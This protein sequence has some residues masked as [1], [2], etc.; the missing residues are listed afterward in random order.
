[1]KKKIRVIII[2]SG[3]SIVALHVINRLITSAATVKELLAK[4]KSSYYTWRFGKIHYKKK[5]TGKPILLIHDLT[6]GSSG[7]EFHKIE[8]ELAKTNEVYT[9]DLLG[10]G[11]SDKPNITYT[12]FLYVE[13]ITDFIKSVIGKKADVLTSGDS[14]SIAIMACHNNAEI[15]NQIVMVNPQ[16]IG[17]SKLIPNKKSRLLKWF[18]ELPV[19]GTFI[20]NVFYNKKNITN[21]FLNQYYCSAGKIEQTDIDAYVEAAHYADH[22]SKYAIASYLGRYM[23]ISMIHALSKINN[24]IYII[25]GMEKANAGAITENYLK[26]NHAIEHHYVESTK[27][28]PHMENPEKTLDI[29]QMYLNNSI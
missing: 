21:S 29:I 2:L 8:N 18:I 13:L 12:N 1:M 27:Q 24:N 6:A 10:Y 25:S 14:S 23:N 4:E 15:I 22:S 28:L 20:Y 3:I 11:L 5:G 17:Y 9:I 16:D 19:V 26:Y 7:Y